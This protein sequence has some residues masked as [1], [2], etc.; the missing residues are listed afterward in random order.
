M[1]DHPR[2][3]A[4]SRGQGR[5]RSVDLRFFRP[6]LKFSHN[7]VTR[8]EAANLA[9]SL[10]FVEQAMNSSSTAYEASLVGSADVDSG[11]GRPDSQ[12]VRHLVVAQP[13]GCQA[14]DLSLSVGEQVE[15]CVVRPFGVIG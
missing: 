4:C 3:E 10:M 14:D 6:T 2:S 13:P 8:N 15:V 9:S 1:E 12:P 11:G 5:R 7:T